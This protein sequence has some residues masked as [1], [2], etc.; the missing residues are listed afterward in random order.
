MVVL[1]AQA[2]ARVPGDRGPL[3]GASGSRLAALAGIGL[4]ALLAVERRNL[5]TD[6][7]GPGRGGKGDLF[8]IGAARQAAEAMAVELAGCDVVLLGAAVAR[9]FRLRAPAYE[10]ADLSGFRAA[11]MPHPSGVCRAYNDPA[12]RARARAFLA[13]LLGG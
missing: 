13:P 3:S 7:L 6:Y 11:W 10:W 5:L 8:R 9:A 4:D 12:E 1:V 2:P